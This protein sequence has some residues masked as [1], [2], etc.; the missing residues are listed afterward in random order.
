ML[1]RLDN[2]LSI[3]RLTTLSHLDDDFP[4]NG[5]FTVPA[6]ELLSIA[7]EALAYREAESK[8]VAW[9]RKCIGYDTPMATCSEWQLKKWNA[10]NE[11]I[12]GHDVITPLYASPVLGQTPIN[13]ELLE[14]LH[15]YG[16]MSGG[17][18]VMEKARSAI[19]AAVGTMQ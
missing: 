2:K 11:S 5:F 9:M 18:W 15:D 12:G 14:A 10:S 6:K 16:S 3:E 17:E 7:R 4:T 1:K 19:A 8:P 13:T